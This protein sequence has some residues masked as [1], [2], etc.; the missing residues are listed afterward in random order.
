MGNDLIF[1]GT[2]YNEFLAEAF[3]KSPELV[4]KDEAGTYYIKYDKTPM[5]TNYQQE[6]MFLVRPKEETV[7]H[8]ARLS[9]IENLGAYV[10][11]LVSPTKREIYDRIYSQTPYDIIDEESNTV[12]ITPPEKFGIFL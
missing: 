8:F 5:Q 10:A 9:S 2:N 7:G 4:G 3:E 1:W 12:T 11:V 6:F